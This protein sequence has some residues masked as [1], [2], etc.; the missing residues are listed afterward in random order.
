MDRGVTYSVISSSV[1]CIKW[2]HKLN[3]QN[4]PTENGFVS[5]LL[6][7]AKRLRSRKVVK[8]D[9]VSSNMLKDLC[10][11]Y[12]DS[13]DLLQIRDLAMILIA[14]AG[15]LRY[16]ELRNLKCRN[17]HFFEE[18]FCLQIESSKTD[19]YRSGNEVLISKG[20][21]EACPY[22]MLQ[23]YI[24]LAGIDL[25]S[26]HYLFKPIFRSGR[27]CKLISKNKPLSYTR[28][29][30]CLVGKL[31][32]V[33]PNLNLGLHSLRAG[34]A[35]TAARAGV[36]DRCLKRHGRWRCDASKDGYIEDTTES[37]LKISQLLHL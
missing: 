35:T 17:V 5:N 14:F 23:K 8:K 25:V 21:S 20:T 10:L 2:V 32:S 29:K 26:D 36:N 34:G 27:I 1:Y 28:A 13:E 24:S 33:H 12:K 19:Q 22:L 11:K 3:G 31:K 6:E 37:K 16:D 30:E 7:S 4:D 18:Y 9:A 15:F